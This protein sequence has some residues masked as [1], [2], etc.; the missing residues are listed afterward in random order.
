MTFP[1]YIWKQAPF[2]R[3]V[4]PLAGGIIMQHYLPM[5]AWT[6]LITATTAVGAMLLFNYRPSFR[7]FRFAWING[8]FINILLIALGCL[9]C[10]Y[11]YAAQHA[12]NILHHYNAGAYVSATIEEPL[13]EK[14]KSFR[15]TAIVRCVTKN[16]KAL[17]T[18][19]T[20]LLYFQK[21][22][23]LPALPYGS[24]IVFNKPLQ[25]IQNSG[26]PGAFD[27]SRY[28]SFQGIFYQVYLQRQ[29]FIVLPNRKENVFKKI[30]TAIHS[31]VLSVI[32]RYI[33]GSREAGLAEAL[34]I[35]YKGDLDKELEKTYANTGVV[36]IIAI[37]GMHLGLIYWLLG[38]A[39]I[40]LAKRKSGKWIKPLVIIGGLWLFALLAGGSPSVLRSAIMFTCIVVGESFSKKAAIYNTLAASA[41]ILL[42]IHPFWL[43]DAGFILSYAAV[44]SIVIFMKPVYNLVYVRNKLLDATWKLAAVTLAAQVLTVPVSIFYFHQFPVYFLFTNIVAVPL[45][46]I[47]VLGEIALCAIAVWPAVAETTGSILHWLIHAMNSFVEHMGRLPFALWQPLQI[48]M[49]QLILMYGF[50]TAAGYWLLEKYKPA[51]I[52]SLVC[53]AGFIICRTCS[54]IETS[55]RQQ[56]IVYNIPKHSAIDFFSN[57]YY[58]SGIS[59]GGA[60]PRLPANDSRLLLRSAPTAGMPGLVAYNGCF[61]FGHKRIVVIDNRYRYRVPA[62]RMKADLVILSR[63]P[64]LSVADLVKVMDM[65]QLVIDASN[66]PVKV[67]KWKAEAAKLRLACIS[68]VD[69]GAFVMKLR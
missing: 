5:P 19:G 4:I 46:S 35:G 68:V 62:E 38:L 36:H 48:D 67:N 51:F 1:I 47:I 3:L 26:N 66:P 25:R 16:N 24:V 65:G 40:P 15:T 21:D 69:N 14:N 39:C 32:K 60:D 58:K 55:R 23:P 28:A 42:C 34:L 45:S 37:S 2:L 7:Q 56:I 20:I 18:E 11:Q 52:A 41:F 17:A 8:L 64:S 61:L 31:K 43:W 44:L 57:G 22:G 12:H 33:P 59:S 53:I 10:R 13:L 54:I 63:S 9:L 29:D 50:I 27:Y 30:L 49:A 6:I